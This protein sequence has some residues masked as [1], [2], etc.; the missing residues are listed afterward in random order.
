M[1]LYN[2]SILYNS[3]SY[4]INLFELEDSLAEVLALEHT[5]ETL[6]GVVNTLG[7]VKFGLDTAVSEPLLEVLLVLLVIG[8]AECR[9]ADEETLHLDLLGDEVQETLDTLALVGGGV[10][11]GDLKIVSCV[12]FENGQR[13]NLPDRRRGYGHRR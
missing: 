13:V 4:R 9:V 10:V 8:R 3:S 5:N 1:I 2:P 6:S 11:L 12:I 7:N